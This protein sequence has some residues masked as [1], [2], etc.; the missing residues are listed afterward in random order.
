MHLTINSMTIENLFVNHFMSNAWQ[1]AWP[2]GQHIIIFDDL[3]NE[4]VNKK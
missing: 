3:K 2:I 1:S 4:Y